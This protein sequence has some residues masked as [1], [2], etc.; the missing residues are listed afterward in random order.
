MVDNTEQEPGEPP[1]QKLYLS[2][3]QTRKERRS[4][5]IRWLGALSLSLVVL[6]VLW[7]LITGGA[8]YLN[9]SSASRT[10]SPV[11]TGST[12]LGATPAIT[13]AGSF[14]SSGPLPLTATPL[15]LLPKPAGTISASAQLPLYGR[16][17][18]LDPGHGPRGDAGAVLTDPDT[19]KLILSEDDFNL[20]VALR[21]RDL[22]RARGAAVVLTREAAD[23]F[24]APWPAD[25][26]GD[27]I[28][29][30]SGDDLQERVDILNNFKAEVFLSIHANGGDPSVVERQ[31]VQVVYCGDSDCNFA[32]QSKQLGHLVSDQLDSK[33]ADA[34]YTPDGAGLV[35]DLNT[36]SSV[37]PQHL[38]LLGPVNPPRHVRATAMPGVLAESL[39][40]SSPE[41]AAQLNKE[42]VRQAI[43]LA[44]ADALQAFLT[45]TGGN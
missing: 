22:L 17:I 25:A 13:A 24:T 18:G 9:A 23:T 44:Y 29:G 6:P 35:T 40:V 28:V 42:S 7:L 19:G 8:T 39:Y 26:N 32:E 2:L 37:P 4:R 41:Q 12:S 14:L 45:G 30:A 1:A 16:R 10:I 20:D 31:D 36:D 43:A 34:G 5:W 21:T 15:N 38:F 11:A 27:G 3:L 33:L